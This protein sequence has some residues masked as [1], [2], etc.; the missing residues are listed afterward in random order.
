MSVA[1]TFEGNSGVGVVLRLPAVFG[2]V[3]YAELP[4]RLLNILT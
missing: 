2:V 4:R 3:V 1:A